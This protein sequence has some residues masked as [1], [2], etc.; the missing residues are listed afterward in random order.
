MAELGE[1]IAAL[2]A[3]FDAEKQYQHDRWH[4]L[5][6]DLTPLV[7]LPERL[8]REIGKLQG[9]FEGRLTSVSREFER[10]MEAAITK[11]LTPIVNDVAELKSRVETLETNR[12]QL[13]GAKMFGV[14]LVQTILAAIVAI[15]ALG[16]TTHP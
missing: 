7:N 2:A 1:R 14:W 11:A 6:N 4:K 13:S 15:V 9:I 3:S 10:S 5:D 16:K 8:T 12:N